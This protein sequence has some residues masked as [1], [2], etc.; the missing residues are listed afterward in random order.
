MASIVFLLIEIVKSLDPRDV[1]VCAD[2]ST[3]FALKEKFKIFHQIYIFE[4]I[5]F[6]QMIEDISEYDFYIIIDI[7][8]RPLH[9]TLLDNISNHFQTYYIT[10][11][12]DLSS[13][14][15]KWRINAHNTIE[16]DKYSISVLLDYLEFTHFIIISSLKYE[17]I[18]LAN[19]L[20]SIFN[21][22][23]FSYLKYNEEIDEDYME[24]Y[25]KK[26]IKAKGVRKMLI[27]DFGTSLEILE[28]K[29]I[30]HNLNSI[31]SCFILKGKSIVNSKIEG[32]LV[33]VEQGLENSTSLEDY[34]LNA[35]NRFL[36][37]INDLM[38]SN[39]FMLQEKETLNQ[40]IS[41][42]LA[43]KNQF[44]IYSLI[45]I[46]NN[47]KNVIG[48]IQE[49]LI[50]TSS[51]AFPG[52]STSLIVSE[53]TKLHLS[54]ANGTHEIYNMYT[55]EYFAYWYLGALYAVQRSNML[56][57]I[58]EFKI[59]LYSV[60]CGIFLYEENW[61]NNC[62][63][64]SRNNL[65]LAYL[66]SIWDTAA[67]GTLLTLKT[68][69]ISL[70]QISPISLDDKLDNKTTFSEFLKLSVSL[71][72]FFSNAF[73]FQ[74]ALGWKN[75]AVLATDDSTFYT[76]YNYVVKYSALAG[77]NIV[78]DKN[79]RILPQNYT[80]A[81]FEKY[82]GHF[83][84]LKDTNCRVVAI[85]ASDRGL[86]W[87]G[88]Y[89]VGL[90]RGDII[91]IG[92]SAIFSFLSG[93]EDEYLKKREALADGALVY[94]YREWIGDLGEKLKSEI[95]SLFPEISYMCMTYDT[96]STVKESIIYI[97]NKGEDYEDP[98]ILKKAMRNIKFT[99]CLGTVFFD[100]DSNSRANAQFT[101]QQLR[102]SAYNNSWIITDVAYLD[103]FSSNI[104]TSIGE[105]SWPTSEST[106][107]NFR[108]HNSC[109][110]DE[111]LIQDSKASK[112]I[113]MIA[114]IIVFII[115]CASAYLSYYS[116]KFQFSYLVE[117]RVITLS[118]M[119]FTSYFLFQIFQLISMGPDQISLRVALKNIQIL[120]AFDFNEFFQV[121]FD[122]FWGLYY[123]VLIFSIF[124]IF[125]CIF[126][127]FKCQI[128]YSRL[129]LFQQIKFLSTFIFPV[130]GHIGFLPIISMLMNIFM[131]H[132]A[133]ANDITSS[134]LDQDCR[135]FCY[136]GKHKFY[137]V[138]SSFCIIFY[139]FTAISC[140]PLWEKTQESLNIRTK[141]VYLS[142]LSIFQVI[143]VILNKNLKPYSQVAHGYILSGLIIAMMILTFYLDP[144]N[145]KKSKVLQMTSL[146][147][148]FWGIFTASIFMNRES[149][150]AWMITE[151][152]GFG[153]IGIAGFVFLRRIPILLYA[154]KGLDVSTLIWYQFAKNNEK[155]QLDPRTMEVIRFS[156]GN[157]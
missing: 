46:K 98:E 109:P 45:N 52:N 93:V 119:I 17:S 147:I 76:E 65:G 72:E 96:V 135:A 152:I 79:K 143:A 42:Y 67:L 89:D 48:T 38:F 85:F 138:L 4:S 14:S 51:I 68:L 54:I 88:L 100:R 66:S 71:K 29:I 70:P 69:G 36:A 47:K 44:P 3:P 151:F 53:A 108:P 124:W 83:Q 116:N 140:R 154:E 112:L 148:S 55:I 132:K 11:T 59:E 114:S 81:D 94:K 95:S 123:C 27:I 107:S 117:R 57:E 113:L 32:S 122:Q 37:K 8:L 144:Y 31:G 39:H 75:L 104:I 90:R 40:I 134:Y 150:Q 15:S 78:N 91:L 50:L 43:A 24:N 84:A 13:V 115:S 106:P 30:D 23:V 19:D 87:E 6:D 77:V 155:S 118:D 58:P 2:I 153:F 16:Q 128:R 35:V 80:R 110:F 121:K 157:K 73:I 139:L 64:Q 21:N 120:C 101:I 82:K 141:S 142:F 103:K 5:E 86:I 26:L 130:L 63:N 28:N 127:L 9:F 20:F 74:K 156:L 49:A 136:I 129:V 125:C 56:N 137:V 41:D 62:L 146:G 105:F 131:C 1:L 22:E 7:T 12:N 18:S 25:V 10:I 111:Y 97:L 60:D 34:E 126:V 145:Y 61:Y 99:G 102:K 33:V 92:E 149:I 133:I